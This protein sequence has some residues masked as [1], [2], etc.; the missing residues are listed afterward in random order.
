MPG[1]LAFLQRDHRGASRLAVDSQKFAFSRH[2]WRHC[3]DRNFTEY[4]RT[5]RAGTD[6]ALPAF[7]DGWGR[8]E[9]PSVPAQGAPP[10]WQYGRRPAFAKPM[11]RGRPLGCFYF[12]D[13]LVGASGAACCSGGLDPASM[14]CVAAVLSS[15]ARAQTHARLTRKARVRADSTLVL[16][17]KDISLRMPLKKETSLPCS[18]SQLPIA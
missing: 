2:A 1:F 15:S 3:R 12:E 7:C 17:T 4:W 6:D 16:S 9:L 13:E 11:A 10:A 5:R 8:S 14:E 18:G